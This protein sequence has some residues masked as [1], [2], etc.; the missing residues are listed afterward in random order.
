M[1]KQTI[2]MVKPL[3]VSMF[4]SLNVAYVLG[5]L[6]YWDK[7]HR[8]EEFYNTDQEFSDQLQIGLKALRAAKDVLKRI[9]VV[10]VVLR[11]FPSK[12]Y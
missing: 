7:I 8:G 3:H 1:N 10:S 6:M 12:T 9:G 11:S 4:G 5:Q 2:V